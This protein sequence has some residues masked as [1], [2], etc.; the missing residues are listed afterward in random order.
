M[1]DGF[2]DFIA[3]V[4]DFCSYSCADAMF[5]QEVSC[6]FCCFDVEAQFVETTDQRQCFFF[7]FVCDGSKY[8]TVV[9]NVHAGS[10]QSFIQRAVQFVVVTDCFPCGFHFGGQVSVHTVQFGEGE[11][12]NFYIPS[13]LFVGVDAED[14]LFFQ[15]LAQDNQCCDVCQRVTCCFGQERYC[16]GGT[17]VHFD[18]VYIVVLIHDELDVEQTADTDAQ[19][20]F[21]GVFQDGAFCFCGYAEGR[22]YADRVTGVYAGSFYMFHDTGNEYIVTVAY[23]VYF[24]FFAFDIFVNQYRLVFVDFNGCFQ[25]CAQGFFVGNDLHCTTAQNVAGANQY[26]IADFFCCFYTVFDVCNCLTLR[27]R[28]VQFFHDFFKGISVFC[29]FD[30]SNV[31]TD[32]FYAAFHQRLCQVDSRLTAQRSDNAQRLFQFYDVHNV[33]CCQRFEVQLVAGCVV[34]G[35]SFRVVVDDDGFITILFDGCY[36][37]YGGVV[38]FDTLTDTDGT[39]TQYNDFLLVA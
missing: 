36:S 14:A 38:E 34:C 16:S 29:S 11:C 15:S 1:A 27:L 26:G 28:D 18:Y 37:M 13:V 8:G 3:A 10:L 24:Q 19:T 5:F 23:C 9:Q 17:R 4:A 33:F 7:V 6:A 2:D 21:L 20:Q 30:G 39:G 35:Y 31:C 25:V 22:V 32:D 12:G